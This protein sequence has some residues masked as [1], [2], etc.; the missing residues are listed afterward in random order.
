MGLRT[1]KL[2]DSRF[3]ANSK[4][5][6]RDDHGP[7]QARL[8]KNEGS[9][10]GWCTRTY[11]P[12]SEFLQIDFGVVQLFTGIALQGHARTAVYNI[13][14]FVLGYSINGFEWETY[15]EHQLEKEF[16]GPAR[17]IGDTLVSRFHRIIARFIRVIPK[18]RLSSLLH[19][20]RMEMFGCAP[21]SPIFN[22]KA[23]TAR[24][25]YKIGSVVNGQ[26]SFFGYAPISK[27]V[28]VEISSAKNS[29]ELAKNIVQSHY[30]E[31]NITTKYENGTF[32]NDQIGRIAVSK[33]KEKNVKN[34]VRIKYNLPESGF[35]NFDI[36]FNSTVSTLTIISLQRS[37][38]VATGGNCNTS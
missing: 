1:G 29:N 35:C 2:P 3:T 4:W 34:A 26:I 31:V 17:T 10:I 11:A 25:T 13:V 14:K 27:Q 19:C 7:Q 24:D 8:Y 15:K 28:T 9:I 22:D 21:T 18:Q 23:Y 36:A 32:L 16:N 38:V 12:V 30:E 37:I 6:D 33:D 20:I 5:S